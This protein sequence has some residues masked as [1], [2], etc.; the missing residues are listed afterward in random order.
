MTPTEELAQRVETL[1]RQIQRSRRSVRIL[2]ACLC[3]TAIGAG[4]AFD[5]QKI[6]L[7]DDQG[8]T[9]ISIGNF[10][11][12]DS[13]RDIIVRDLNGRNRIAIGINNQGD[14]YINVFGKNGQIFRSLVPTPN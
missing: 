13:T 3:M 6:D 10:I 1:E 14:A 9:G 5:N 7:R 12:G 11:A 2:I 8:R 4:A